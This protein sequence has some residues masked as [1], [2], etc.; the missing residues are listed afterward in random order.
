MHPL[1]LPKAVGA[2][3][4]A[5][6]ALALAAPVARHPT[7]ERPDAPHAVATASILGAATEIVESAAI[8][9]AS[10]LSWHRSREPVL[11]LGLAFALAAAVAAAAFCLL[12]R[13]TRDRLRSVTITANGMRAPP[14]LH[15]L[16]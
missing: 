4:V 3:A 1:R 7:P 2:L 8:E 14:D 5:I 9:A 15:V 11:G 10:V 16:S 13:S 6:V 12:V